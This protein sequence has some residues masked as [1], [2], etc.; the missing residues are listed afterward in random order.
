MIVSSIQ[1][2]LPQVPP[3]A[4]LAAAVSD[5]R[6]REQAIRRLQERRA[7][8]EGQRKQYARCVTL[9]QRGSELVND[10][11]VLGTAVEAERADFAVLAARIHHTIGQ[12]GLDALDE[13]DVWE[14][15]LSGLIMRAQQVKQAAIDR[16]NAIQDAYRKV[17]RRLQFSEQQMFA[18]RT[19]NFADPEGSY[20]HLALDV[21]RNIQD[22]INQLG[23]DRNLGRLRADLLQIAQTTALPPHQAADI[24]GE[25]E[26]YLKQIQN[27]DA[28]LQ[29]LRR[30]AAQVPRI[31]DMDE[32]GH[33]MFAELTESLEQQVQSIVA[34]R[35][36]VQSLKQK[37]G[38]LELTAAEKE[39]YAAL[40]ELI[41][42]RQ[43]S[44]DEGGY[45]ELADV[46]KHLS[47][48]TDAKSPPT[49]S[50]LELLGDL[51]D[52]RRV[53][54]KVGPLREE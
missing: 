38:R 47:R 19:F 12:S 9:V 31:R 22:L 29:A 51:Y 16:F 28:F 13:V 6:K 4:D 24:R 25:A 15:E 32:M 50:L 48:P 5:L 53:R 11:G 2:M 36:N 20:D 26:G 8:L 54:I 27:Q 30:Q 17:L 46:Y 35:Y 42:K 39:L 7:G 10:L 1:A 23:G 41:A 52:K 3:I 18:R 33:G 49:R 37:L 14:Q 43:V 45:V 40:Q 44:A 34:L 21:Q